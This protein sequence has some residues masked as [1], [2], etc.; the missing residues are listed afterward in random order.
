MLPQR[1]PADLLPVLGAGGTAHFDG[2][3]HGAQVDGETSLTHFLF[4]GEQWDEFHSKFRAD[5]DKLDAAAFDLRKRGLRATG[6]GSIGWRGGSFSMDGPMRLNAKF[7]GIDLVR[8][9]KL[10][11]TKLPVTSGVASGSLEV[12]GSLNRPLGNAHIL[13]EKGTVYDEHFDRAQLDATIENDLWRIANGR[14]GE[15]AGS[16]SLFGRIPASWAGPFQARQQCFR[17]VD[18]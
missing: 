18:P 13:V 9:K 3:L 10:L 16:A 7:Q 4:Q 14:L 8:D 12:S 5:T 1:V 17:F 11:P 2:V 6:T 15:G